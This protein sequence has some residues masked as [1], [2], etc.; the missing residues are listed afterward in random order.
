[1]FRTSEAVF[2]FSPHSVESSLTNYALYYA[3]GVEVKFDKVTNRP[4]KATFDD[5]M[6]ALKNFG[7][8]ATLLGAYKSLF[9]PCRYEPFE[10]NANG[11][12]PG[13]D[14]KDIFDFNLLR[15][16]AVSTLMLQ[17]YLSA[18]LSAL[19]AIVS[20]LLGFKVKDGMMDNPMLKATSPTDFWAGRWNVLVHGAL[21]RGVFKPV[22]KFSSRFIAVLATFLASG[23]FHDFIL[24]GK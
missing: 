1:M 20:I 4:I 17:L 19:L 5:K 24:F 23:L 18:F 8:Y 12:N 9:G 2:G 21:K 13:Y 10:T 7:F 16:N 6:N 11:N 22:Y 3:A 14:L 15:N